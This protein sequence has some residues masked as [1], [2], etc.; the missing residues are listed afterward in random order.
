[1]RGAGGFVNGDDLLFP[2]F[3]KMY[4]TLTRRF[5]NILAMRLKT[6]YAKTMTEAM[7]MVRETLGED[8][9][10]V[11]TRD[12]NGGKAVRVTAAVEM[13][14]DYGGGGPAFEIGRGAG[15]GGMAAPSRDWLQYDDEE[16]QSVV[17]EA[18]TDALLRHAAPEEITDQI[19]SCA[20]VMALEKPEVA[21]SAALEHLFA[22]R[23]LPVRGQR[24][25]LM[26]V[27]PPGAGKTLAVAKIAARGVM[28]GQ[29]V[30]V[31]SCDTLRAGGLEQLGAFTKLLGIP[32]VK[33]RD[34]AELKTAVE[35]ASGADLVLVDTGG[36]NPFA[37]REVADL[38]RLIAASGGDP[39]LAMPAGGD[40]EESGEVARVFSTIG[41]RWMMPTRLD[42]ARRLGGLLEA[43]HRGSMSFSDASDT[44]QVADG[45][46]LLDPAR[47]C[48]LLMPELQKDSGRIVRKTA[49]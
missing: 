15:G 27:G 23:P 12:E 49:G 39:L 41:V 44:P 22:F 32:L 26:M 37:V 42:I 31:I 1:M 8:A 2:W 18:L 4:Y 35:K 38:A 11:A 33:A 24:K 40:A 7:R 3:Q 25:P 46:S 5:C 36:I 30:A 48:A 17:A 14:G 20:T 6:F 16:E 13:S 45:L 10:I 21:L 47:L 19:L 43:A 34:P 28:N 9:I 29:K